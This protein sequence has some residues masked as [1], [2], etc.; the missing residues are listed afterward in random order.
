MPPPSITAR[1]E[2]TVLLAFGGLNSPSTAVLIPAAHF[3]PQSSF[4]TS[5]C[6]GFWLNQV[7]RSRQASVLSSTS[8]V[9]ARASRTEDVTAGCALSSC[10]C[11]KSEAHL[12]TPNDGQPLDEGHE[13]LFGPGITSSDFCESHRHKAASLSS[14]NGIHRIL[15]L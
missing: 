9:I 3:H 8:Q 5:R 14:P 10:P 13:A 11:P 2:R 6:L 7:W 4:Q 15:V 1:I 12:H